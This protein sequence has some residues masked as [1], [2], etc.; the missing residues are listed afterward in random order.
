[1]VR[2]NARR[3]TAERPF[4]LP[5]LT[6]FSGD[7]LEPRRDYDAIDFV[8]RDFTG[9]DASD[10]RFLECRL[11]RCHL[12]G[13]S[14]RRV[15]VVDSLLSEVRAASVDLTDSTWRDS[16]MSGGRLGAMTLAGAT[17]TGIRVHGSKL[18]FVNLAGAHVEDVVFEACEI[19]SLDARGAQLRSVGFVDCTMDELNIAEA[20]LSKV[21]LSGARLRSLVGVESLRGAIVSH[22]QLLDLAP[23]LA[24][25]L[26]LE[27]RRASSDDSSDP[28]AGR[29][30]RGR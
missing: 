22:E 16:R 19:D 26:G 10:A 15:R 4:S 2:T 30:G 25:Q 29:L 3:A 8:D 18:G 17:W 23:L 12:D 20:T 6:A 9:Q 13:L 28:G 5:D 14:M 27:V 7:R 1:M 11:E 21:D 24:A